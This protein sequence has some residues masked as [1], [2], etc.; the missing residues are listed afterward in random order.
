MHMV[1]NYKAAVKHAN[2]EIFRRFGLQGPY[3]VGT[4][5]HSE[6]LKEFD[7]AFK[8]IIFLSKY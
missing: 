3:K 1:D 4:V 5:E 6:W 2:T 7:R 8:E